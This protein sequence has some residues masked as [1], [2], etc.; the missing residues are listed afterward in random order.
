MSS[1]YSKLGLLTGPR[2][3]SLLIL[4]GLP[5]SVFYRS[6]VFDTLTFLMFVDLMFMSP[7]RV[8]T[9]SYSFSKHK[10]FK[11]A[12]IIRLMHIIARTM[13]MPNKIS[14]YT[15]SYTI[16]SSPLFEVS[17]SYKF[18]LLFCPNIIS[19]SKLFILKILI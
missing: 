19:M 4:I 8:I 6:K 3:V 7:F 12:K 13:A 18:R 1:E 14:Y 11:I 17:S 9:R 10:T 15:D 16:K 2:C 5:D